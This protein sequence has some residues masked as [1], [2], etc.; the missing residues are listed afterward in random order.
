MRIF[1]RQYKCNRNEVIVKY[2]KFQ[3]NY[4]KLTKNR[5]SG[6]RINN[7]WKADEVIKV[8]LKQRFKFFVKVKSFEKSKIIETIMKN[9]QFSKIQKIMI[10][11]IS[12]G[13][14]ETGTNL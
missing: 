12:F 4:L 8:Y 2:I 14:E 13:N 1:K 9:L 7:I 11:L 10:K 3:K 5:F 6:I